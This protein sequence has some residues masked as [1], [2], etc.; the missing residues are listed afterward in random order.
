LKLKKDYDGKKVEV[1]EILKKKKEGFV[2]Q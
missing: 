1:V 2:Q